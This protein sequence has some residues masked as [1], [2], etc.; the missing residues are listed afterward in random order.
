[1]TTT[2]SAL[3]E[4]EGKALQGGLPW[5][6]DTNVHD[7]DYLRAR[8]TDVI[9]KAGRSNYTAPEDDFIRRAVGDMSEL[10][11]LRRLLEG[12]CGELRP[13]GRSGDEMLDI[14]TQSHPKMVWVRC[15]GFI[16]YPNYHTCHRSERAEVARQCALQLRLIEKPRFTV[17]GRQ[18]WAGV[19][20]GWQ[21]GVHG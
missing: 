3:P 16:G 10:S 13:F 12:L 19:V 18:R 15:D 6:D 2:E 7:I 9:A 20:E 21:I 11:Y 5:I 14:L 8:L 1:M 17:S 4:W